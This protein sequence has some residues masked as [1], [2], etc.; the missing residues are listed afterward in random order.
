MEKA[1]QS[2]QEMRVDESVKSNSKLVSHLSKLLTEIEELETTFGL[3]SLFFQSLHVVKEILETSPWC[4]FLR[5]QN[6]IAYSI[7]VCNAQH[8]IFLRG[9]WG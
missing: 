6:G 4:F 1:A 5:Y 9:R 2:F 8:F 3:F 7:W